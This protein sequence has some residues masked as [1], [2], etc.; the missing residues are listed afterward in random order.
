MTN[1][2]GLNTDPYQCSNCASIPVD[3]RYQ[4]P[5]ADV[6]PVTPAE[7]M[8]HLSMLTIQCR[9]DYK[10]FVWVVVHERSTNCNFPSL[11]YPGESISSVFIKVLEHLCTWTGIHPRSVTFSTHHGIAMENPD[12]PVRQYF[13]ERNIL[14]F[15]AEPQGR[16]PFGG[17]VNLRR[18][19]DN[20]VLSAALPDLQ[21]ERSTRRMVTRFRRRCKASN[22]CS[23]SR[24][25]NFDTGL[26]MW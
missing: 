25:K 3:E 9:S 23:V 17:T 12:D 10:D 1:R 18:Y 16:L 5:A 15:H 19:Y 24:F 8:E 4:L 6:P 22:D 13:R 20:V 14:H 21:P 11:V 26:A 2:L 7:F